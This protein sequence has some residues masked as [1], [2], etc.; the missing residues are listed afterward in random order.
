MKEYNARQYKTVI[1]LANKLLENEKKFDYQI[2]RETRNW[3]CLAY[4]REQDERFFDEISFFKEQDD[5]SLVD[6]HFLLGFYYRNGDKM[7][8]AEYHFQE[9]LKINEHHSRSK[10]ELVNV[11]LRNG[12]YM[13][14]LKW[15]E[16]NY[17]RFK[18]NILHI[19]AYFTC[20]VKKHD[21]TEFDFDRLNELLESASKSMDK[22]ARDI[23]REMQAEYDFYIQNNAAS[24]IASL[25]ESLRLNSNNV[26][27]FRSLAEILKRKNMH[28]E[29]MELNEKFQHL[30]NHE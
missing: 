27:A 8:D 3:L 11:Y 15:A 2:I 14:A 19:Q 25:G 22:K 1:Q 5:E 26:Y 6:Y 30:N 29:L 17:R 28:F 20:L 9:V 18:T 21:K 23:S 10:R 13:K 24:A 7:D 12:E 4:S 16:D